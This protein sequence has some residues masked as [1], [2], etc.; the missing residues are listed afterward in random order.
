MS[1][2]NV[3]MNCRQ[4][5]FGWSELC[6]IEVLRVVVIGK[7]SMHGGCRLGRVMHCVVRSPIMSLQNT[8][9]GHVRFLVR[10]VC[11]VGMSLE[12]DIVMLKSASRSNKT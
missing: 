6:A 11:K 1:R 5:N 7:W 2:N 3:E 8:S 9:L 4:F 10:V 12:S